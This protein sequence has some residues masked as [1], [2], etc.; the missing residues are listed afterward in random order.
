M[1]ELTL[2]LLQKIKMKKVTK[3]PQESSIA[4][5]FRKDKAKT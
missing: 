4:I 3:Q 5:V 2:N 1:G